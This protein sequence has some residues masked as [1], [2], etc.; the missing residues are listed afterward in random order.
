[1]THGSHRFVSHRV[2]GDPRPHLLTGGLA[3]YRIYATADGRW[4]TVGRARSPLLRAAVRTARAPRP[5]AVALRGRPAVPH[6]R[7]RRDLRDANARRVARLL[8]R[9]GRRGRPGRDARGGGRRP[10]RRGLCGT[11]RRGSANIRTSGAP[12]SVSDRGAR[13]ARSARSAPWRRPRWRSLAR[14]EPSFSSFATDGVWRVPLESGSERRI[15]GTGGAVAAAWAPSGREL[16]FERDGIVSTINADGTGA[17]TL[18][19]GGE[20]AWSLDGRWL[21]VV[22]ERSGRRRPAQRQ[23]GAR[24]HVG[25][26]RRTTGVGAGR[27]TACVRPR[28][29]GVGRL[30]VGRARH[31]P[32]RGNRSGLVAGRDA[33]SRSPARPASRRR[34]RRHGR[35]YRHARRRLQLS[36]FLARHVEGA[37]PRAKATSPRTRPTG[38]RARSA[39]ARAS[40]C[41]AFPF[42]QSCSPTSTSGRRARSQ[43]RTSAAGT[44]SDSRP[45]ST[46]SAAGRCGSAARAQGGR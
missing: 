34:R 29:H 44:S 2:A 6:R 8:R 37:S 38:R 21:A 12:S 24:G 42:A 16:A 18:L 13:A 14:C 25:S 20:P 26:H 1:M 9:G 5:R 35:P 23:R 45:P 17:R 41:G 40:T 43:S 39:P 27:A 3:C 33:G 36:G 46:T 31:D 4:L 30:R 19:T 22:R 7:A 15:T 11:P 32:D 10:G 28:R